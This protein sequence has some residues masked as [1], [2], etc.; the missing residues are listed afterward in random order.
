MSEPITWT[1]RTVAEAIDLLNAVEE[2]IDSGM[3]AAHPGSPKN[4]LKAAHDTPLN[5]RITFDTSAVDQIAN[6]RTAFADQVDP[7]SLPDQA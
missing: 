2:R 1:A 4:R 5:L 3:K 6:E 7:L